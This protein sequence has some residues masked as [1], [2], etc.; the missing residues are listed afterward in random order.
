MTIALCGL[1]AL[2]SLAYLFLFAARA[3][4]PLAGAVVKTLPVALLA[5]AGWL[6][7]APA[8]IW[9]GLAFG[10]LGDFLLAR[11][12][13]PAFLAGMGAFAAG[14]LAYAL[15]FGPGLPAPLAAA[16]FVALALSTEVWLAPHTGALKWPVRGYALIICVMAAMATLRPTPLLV[17]GAALFVASDLM[18][19]VQMFRARGTLARVLPWLVWPCY[20]LGQA[21]IL[22][23][24]LPAAP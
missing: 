21:L 22:A 12:G 16:P 13:E 1:S 10:A 18:L 15:A 2:F 4:K 7:G 11:E 20:W 5:L 6:G 14:H 24:F 23:A 8:L 3:D 19:A 17:S 9:G